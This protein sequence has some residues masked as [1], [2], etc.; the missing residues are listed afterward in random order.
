MGCI[1]I[2]AGMIFKNL[3]PLWL[4]IMQILIGTVIFSFLT[5]YFRRD[6][7]IE[8]KDMIFLEELGNLWAY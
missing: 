7:L 5:Y 4:L 2:I 1:V 6:F 3:G 8:F